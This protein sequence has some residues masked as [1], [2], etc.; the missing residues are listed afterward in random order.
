MWCG[1]QP[2]REVFPTIYCTASNPLASIA[3]LQS[4]GHWEVLFTKN[5]QEWELEEFMEIW[6]SLQCCIVGAAQQGYLVS[7]NDSVFTVRKFFLVNANWMNLAC[8][9]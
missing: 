4:E 6:P 2:L 3:E 8:G 9:G 7:T 5:A 1:E